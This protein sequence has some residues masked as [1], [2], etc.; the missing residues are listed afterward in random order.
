MVEVEIV[1]HKSIV[2]ETGA[3]LI[4]EDQN[5]QSF[6]GIGTVQKITG[7]TEL[8]ILSKVSHEGYDILDLDLARRVGAY[9][10]SEQKALYPRYYPYRGVLGGSTGQPFVVFPYFIFIALLDQT[11]FSNHPQ[12]EKAVANFRSLVRV[13]QRTS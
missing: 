11:A 4:F 6:V 13:V 5:Q 8:E 10:T 12:H 3:L 9:L 1:G 2:L 7:L